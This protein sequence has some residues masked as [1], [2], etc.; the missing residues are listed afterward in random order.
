M[1][2]LQDKKPPGIPNAPRS[3]A[4]SGRHLGFLHRKKLPVIPNGVRAVRNP[5]SISNM[6]THA[7]GTPASA[8]EFRTASFHANSWILRVGAQHCCAP[9]PQD[10]SSLLCA[11]CGPNSVPSAL[12]PFSSSPA[13]RSPMPPMR[14]TLGSLPSETTNSQRPTPNSLLLPF[15]TN[16]LK[17]KTSHSAQDLQ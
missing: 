8:L 3:A 6:P 13:T 1:P 9:C 11:L 17:L 5:S 15:K 12:R 4:P 10:P 16:N 7:T 14:R 2:P